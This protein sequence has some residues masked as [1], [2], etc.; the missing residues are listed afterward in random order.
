MKI[1]KLVTVTVELTPCDPY[2]C[3]RCG[4]SHSLPF[5][6]RVELKVARASSLPWA[7]KCSECGVET[8]FRQWGNE[9]C[10][11]LA[12]CEEPPLSSSCC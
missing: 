3:P 2:S 1:D 7:W 9:A 12:S 11:T 10:A 4:Q 5:D 8:D 6:V